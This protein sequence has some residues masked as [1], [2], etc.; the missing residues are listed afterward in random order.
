MF[1]FVIDGPGNVLGLFVMF[2]CD[3]SPEPIESYSRNLSSFAPFL[4]LPLFSFF[5]PFLFSLSL[6][7]SCSLAHTHLSHCL[8]RSLSLSLSLSRSHSLSLGTSSRNVC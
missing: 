2:F 3:C 8:S 6:C 5:H 1:E 7:R 4:P